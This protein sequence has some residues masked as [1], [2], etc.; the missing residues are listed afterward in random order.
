MP[1]GHSHFNTPPPPP[2]APP[3]H[4]RAGLSRAD[5]DSPSRY[6]EALLGREATS[7]RLVGFLEHGTATLRFYALWDDRAALHGDR[8]PLK[9]HYFLA[10]DEVGGCGVCGVRG[11]GGARCD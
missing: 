4:T 3:T 6:A 11:G 7:K 10:T 1:T 9:L 8:R 2:R 5:E